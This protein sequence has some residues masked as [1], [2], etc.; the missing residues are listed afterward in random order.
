MDSVFDR[1]PRPPCADLLG[2]RLVDQDRENGRVRIEFEARPEFLNP[3]G[4]VQGGI[5]AAM[6]DDTMGPAAL[7]MSDGAV[8]TSTIDMNVTFLAPAKPGKLYG[9]GRVVQLGKTIVY[10]EAQLMD[11]QNNVLARATSS[12][13]AVNAAPLR[14]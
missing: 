13:R 7:V 12:A 3:A 11:A 14:G 1:V 8:F 9:E 4:F 6:L 5:L 2:W 10:L